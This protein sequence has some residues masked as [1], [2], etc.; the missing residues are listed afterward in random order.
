MLRLERHTNRSSISI[1]LKIEKI[2][3]EENENCFLSN[4]NFGFFGEFE[5]LIERP[6]DR[7]THRVA[8]TKFRLNKS[9]IFQK[10]FQL[11]QT[12]FFS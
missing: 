11:F 3:E 1:C 8:L 5:R 12:G 7:P 10:W 9:N 4:L 2:F 6:G